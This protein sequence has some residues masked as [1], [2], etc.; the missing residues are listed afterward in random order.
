MQVQKEEIKCVIAFQK[1]SLYKVLG[2]INL[3][4]T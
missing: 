1:F 4:I 3:E 2:N